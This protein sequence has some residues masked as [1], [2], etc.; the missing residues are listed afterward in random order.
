MPSSSDFV[1]IDQSPQEQQCLQW[2]SSYMKTIGIMPI[3]G[4]IFSCTWTHGLRRKEGK[5]K[6]WIVQILF[7]VVP[8]D[9]RK[10]NA[11]GN[12]ATVLGVVGKTNQSSSLNSS[13]YAGIPRLTREVLR[14]GSAFRGLN[15]QHHVRISSSKALGRNRKLSCVSKQSTHRKF[16]SLGFCFKIT[17][18]V[19]GVS[20]KNN[21]AFSFLSLR[22]VDDTHG[23]PN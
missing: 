16:P 11:F 10:Q 22:N 1:H 6:R 3:M 13:F 15:G 12:G 7:F 14:Q 20:D 19:D 23:L 8:S 5:R 4:F 9:V 17:S 18:G 2:Q 21:H